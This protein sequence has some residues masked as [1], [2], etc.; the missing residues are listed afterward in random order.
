MYG[1][2]CY[3]TPLTCNLKKNVKLIDQKLSELRWRQRETTNEELGKD[4]DSSQRK[5]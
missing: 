1:Q 5:R 2:Q 3:T 4:K